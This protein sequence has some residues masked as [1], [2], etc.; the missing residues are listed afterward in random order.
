MSIRSITDLAVERDLAAPDE[1][2][3]S[4]SPGRDKERMRDGVI[5]AIPAEILT[6]YTALTGGTLAVLI[7]DHATSYLP[8]R[9]AILVFALVLTPATIYTAYRRKFAARRKESRLDVQLMPQEPR[10]PY[11][12]MTASTLA[13]AAWFLAAPGSPLLATLSSNAAEL[14]SSAIIIGA[15][16]LLTVGFGRPLSTGSASTPQGVPDTSQGAAVA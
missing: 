14:T 1:A 6:L 5:S 12:E 10:V 7:R 16:S 15:A 2:V 9:W 8:Y 3:D 13:A 11:L 4:H